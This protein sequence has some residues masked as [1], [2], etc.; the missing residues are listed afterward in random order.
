VEPSSL[1][2]GIKLSLYRSAQDFEGLIHVFVTVEILALAATTLLVFWPRVLVAMAHRERV[3][4][5][6]K[7]VFLF[8]I[9]S[10]LFLNLSFAQSV[11]FSR[12]MVSQLC[13]VD[14]VVVAL[15]FF[16]KYEY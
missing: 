11:F 7:E 13:I 3:A 1:F 8:T 15:V 6:K 16:R 2:F 9:L 12:E 10:I 14:G 4:A 5:G